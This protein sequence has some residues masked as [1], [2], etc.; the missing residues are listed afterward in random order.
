MVEKQ[1]SNINNI[2]SRKQRC[3]YL[4][5]KGQKSKGVVIVDMVSLS[6]LLMQC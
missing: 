3:F 2:Y 5:V 4:S 1:I 6:Q